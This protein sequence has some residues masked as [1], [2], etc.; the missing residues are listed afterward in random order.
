MSRIGKAPI[1]IP[2]GVTIEHEA[3][4]VRVKGPKGELSQ[5]IAE[6]ME[7]TIEDGELSVARPSEQKKHKAMHGLYRAL[8]NN[9]VIGVTEGYKKELELVGVGY[10]AVANGQVLEMSLGYSHS[11]FLQVPEEVKVSAETAKGKNPIITLESYDKQLLGQ[12]AAKIKSLRK[13]EPYKGKGIRFV[14]EQVRRK[15]GK[16]AGK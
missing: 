4:V 1:T 8:I 11:V 3:N 7:V 10:K 15:A 9:M 12:V 13:V 16:S 2:G 6:G 14:G 5:V